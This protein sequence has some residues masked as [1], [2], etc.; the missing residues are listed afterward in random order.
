[1]KENLE[2]VASQADKALPGVEVEIGGK[3]RTL[4]YTLYALCKL[5]EKTGKNPLDGT[6]FSAMRPSDVVAVLWA[7]LLHEEP[8]LNADELAKQIDIVQLRAVS[9]MM[10]RAFAQAA[11]VEDSK[12]NSTDEEP[13]AV[14]SQE[15]PS[16]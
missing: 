15:S 8:E 4:K 16:A 7:G 2:A 1:M 12:K 3:K 6:M 5:D 10:M 13:K 14:T 11:P 9:E